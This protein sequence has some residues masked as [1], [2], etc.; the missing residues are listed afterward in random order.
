[1]ENNIVEG[2]FGL[3][4]WQ[5]RQQQLAAQQSWGD[6]A[7]TAAGQSP[8][9]I[10]A[11][12]YANM[13]T[14]IGNIAGGMLGMENPAVAEAKAREV[15]L[16]G[17]DTSNPEAI[18]QRAA[19]VQDPRLKMR[20]TQ[21]AQQLNA[22]QQEM[23]L[24][25]AQE[26]AQLNKAQS[27]SSPFAKINPKDYTQESLLKYVQTKNPADLIAIEATEKNPTS[28]Q[29]WTLAGK[30][31]T[32]DAWLIRNKRAGS[33]SINMPTQEKGFETELGKKQAETLIAGRAAADDAVEIINTVNEGR[34]I[35]NQGMVTGFGADVI[36]GIGQA[37]KQA[38]VDFGGDATSN[39]QAYTANMA[40]NVGKL[41]KQFGAGTG[42]S[43]ADRQYAT[44]MAGGE[45]NLDEKAIK[46]ILDINEKAARNVIRLHN[47]RA[48]GVK[49]NIPLTV[50]E[51]TKSIQVPQSN[52]MET[53]PSPSKLTGKTVR[54]TITGIRYKSDGKTW[55]KQ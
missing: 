35:L 30:P 7:A 20:L 38:G 33:T 26:L 39:A 48:S 24:K 52:V 34:N 15:A 55:V 6:E 46:K 53:L 36:V 19:Q 2:L 1:M 28:Y 54:D 29:E 43:D 27:E 32:F 17:L 37:L 42:L 3:S 41:I 44:K 8:G 12:S 5:V 40:Q 21:L 25:R 51:P 11:R 45:I 10:M 9:Q 18:M 13:G 14:G 47:K 50:E 49:T 4:P 31:G 23:A 22:Q 16:S